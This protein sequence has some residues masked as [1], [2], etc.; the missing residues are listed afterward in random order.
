[1]GCLVV[2]LV[3]AAGM[4][5]LPLLLIL[6]S[7]IFAA[8]YSVQSGESIQ[9]ALDQA[10]PGDEVIVHAG[11]YHEEVRF[12]N[13][14]T[15]NNYITLKAAEGE[16]VLLDGS[17][18]L[19]GWTQCSSQAEALGNP[20][21][22]QIYYATIPDG[23][24]PFSANLYEE[25]TLLAVAQDPNP[26]DPLYFKMPNEDW[27][28]IPDQGYTDTQIINPVYFSQSDP[29]Y[30]DGSY[31]MVWSGNNN[32]FIRKILTFT[33]G[34]G[35]ITFDH[36]T[37]L[38]LDRDTFAMWNHIS[39]IDNPGEYYVDESNNRVYLWPRSLSNLNAVTVSVLEYG[40]AI[41]GKSYVIVDGFKIRRYSCQER[42][43]HRGV[44]IRNDASWRC[45]DV[46]VRNNEVTQTG[47]FGYPAIYMAGISNGLADNN[48]IHDVPTA[49]IFFSGT[50]SGGHVYNNTISNNRLTR[51]GGTGLRY[52]Y[53]GNSSIINNTNIDSNGHHANGITCYL[54]S[55]DILI[56]GNTVINC[57]NALTMNSVKNMT[58]TNNIFHDGPDT[59]S[60]LLL[61]VWNGIAENVIIDHNTIIDGGMAIPSHGKNIMISNNITDSIALPRYQDAE[62]V[63][64]NNLYTG[65]NWNMSENQMGEGA[66]LE[67]DLNNIFIDYDNGD[68][69]LRLGSIACTMSTEGS[70]V[71]AL[72]PNGERPGPNDWDDFFI[73]ADSSPFAVLNNIIGTSFYNRALIKYTG[74]GT[75]TVSIII[76]DSKGR[77]IKVLWEGLSVRMPADLYWYADDS[78]GAD[79]GSGIYFVHLIAGGHSEIRK[80]AVIK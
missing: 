77:I 16:E 12:T 48:Y 66:V 75:D 73:Q 78:S 44:G 47:F 27:I 51:V 17:L 70:F 35:K 79:V 55:H 42:G 41:G 40:V 30:W 54:D 52:Y 46:I 2:G 20:H 39:L 24:T 9:S 38:I 53:V 64:R 56:D 36:T 25:E 31:A 33:P 34:E 72:G 26:P 57:N 5:C 7:K 74:S 4:V 6:A 50:L 69:R 68:F 60:G 61:V 3:M 49:G 67:R 1:M 43:Y 19:T 18:P 37:D 76:Y 45:S 13:S 8:T 59:G 80:V 22:Q 58:I 14:G 10:G 23:V 71:G 11:T 62:Y 65:L 21:W 28:D 32:I 15:E 63:L 29:L